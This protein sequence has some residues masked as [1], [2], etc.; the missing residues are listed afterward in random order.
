M[1]GPGSS[2]RRRWDRQTS[3]RAMTAPTAMPAVMPFPGHRWDVQDR[4]NI[5]RAVSRTSNREALGHGSRRQRG[6]EQRLGR[7]QHAK[8]DARRD[9]TGGLCAM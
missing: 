5:R 3:P 9:G 7:K 2:R 4:T 1:T 6:P 8:Q